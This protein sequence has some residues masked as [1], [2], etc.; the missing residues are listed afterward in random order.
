MLSLLER[1][2]TIAILCLSVFGCTGNLLTLIIVNQRFFRRTASAAFISGLCIADCCVLCLHSLQ[3]VAKLRPQV[4]SYDCVVF[5]FIDVFRLLSV[6]IVCF[7]SIERCSLVFNPCH[8]P[9]LTS[10]IKSRL[11]VL[12][13]FLVSLIIF[14]HYTYHMHIEYVYNANQTK[15]IRSFCAFK[16]DFHR[17]TWE[18]I[19]SALTYWLIVPICIICNFII[20]RRLHQA[21]RIERSLSPDSRTKLDLSSKQRQLTA[22]LVASS[23]CFVVTATPSIVHAIYLLLSRNLSD[24]QYAIHIVTNILLHFHHASNF[25]AFVFSCTRFR[26]ELV[27]LF[28]NY[29]CFKIYTT[30]YK[31]STQHTEQ[32]ILYSTKQQRTPVKLLSPKSNMQKR[33]PP[34]GIVVLAT[35]NYNKRNGRSY[36]HYTQPNYK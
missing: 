24:R 2:R 3:I 19:R 22:M 21:S 27:Q 25:L 10:Q 5:F 15:P 29:F 35:N 4:T 31:R 20:I 7:I 11:L 12:F 23:V 36:V 32:I 6:W 13:L 18:S 8:M 1:I 9:R 16:R 17:L 33:N 30:W 34:N 28:R 26:I 14:S